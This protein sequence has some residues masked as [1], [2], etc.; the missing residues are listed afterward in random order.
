M[1]AAGRFKEHGNGN[2]NEKRRQECQKSCQQN[3][4]VEKENRNE[5]IRAK[6]RRIQGR[7]Q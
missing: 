7:A 5:K 4:A 3:Q 1:V 2:A 6:D